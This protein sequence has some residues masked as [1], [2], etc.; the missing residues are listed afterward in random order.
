MINK[1]GLFY[2][3]VGCALHEPKN[4]TETVEYRGGNSKKYFEN[5]LPISYTLRVIAKG[6]FYVNG[7]LDLF[8]SYGLKVSV[9]KN[10]CP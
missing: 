6:C 5:K 2:I 8:H 3:G 10:V 1:T 4:D 7:T 9:L